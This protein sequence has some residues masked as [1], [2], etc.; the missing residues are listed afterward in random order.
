MTL[1]GMPQHMGLRNNVPDFRLCCRT[2]TLNPLFSFLYW[3]MNYHTEHHMYP[4]VPCYNLPRLH[5]LIRHD[6]PHTHHGLLATWLEIAY[7]MSRQKYEPGFQ[8]DP[9]LPGTGAR[10]RDGTVDTSEP[11]SESAS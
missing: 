6:L 11:L 9:S 2:M 4:V 1:V 3:R 8:L 10:D 5:A 7:T